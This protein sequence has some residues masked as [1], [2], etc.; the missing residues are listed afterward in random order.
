MIMAFG[1]IVDEVIV[2]VHMDEAD[3]V[4]LLVKAAYARDA[5]ASV[6]GDVDGMALVM[7][8]PTAT[9]RFTNMS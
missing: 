3:T 2:E 6:F 8:R 1:K 5:L 4:T 9:R 7:T